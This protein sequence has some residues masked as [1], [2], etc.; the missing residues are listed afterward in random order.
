MVELSDYERRK[1]GADDTQ[2]DSQIATL[3]DIARALTRTVRDLEARVNGIDQ[4]ITQALPTSDA[5]DPTQPAPW[6]WYSPP[7]AAEDDPDNDHDPRFTIDNFIAWYNL[8]FVGI[9]GSRAVPIPTC[10]EQHEGLAMEITT[11]AYTWRAANIG[12]TANPRDAQQWLHQWRPGFTERLTR[13]WVHPDCL[14]NHHRDT[15]SPARANRFT[16]A[17]QHADAQ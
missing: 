15:N 7:A 9:D 5:T 14:D 4:T 2:R 10:W 6:V 12:P 13:D 3:T 11:L 17:E 1:T 16:L 8:T